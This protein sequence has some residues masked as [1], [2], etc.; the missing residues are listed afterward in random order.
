LVGVGL[1][2][3]FGLAAARHGPSIDEGKP[4]TV[5]QPSLAAK[6]AE[7]AAKAE[8]IRAAYV[9]AMLQAATAPAR[10]VEHAPSDDPQVNEPTPDD[11]VRQARS[12]PIDATWAAEQTAK[13]EAELSLAS[14]HLD[15]RYD[16]LACRTKQCTVDLEWRTLKAARTAF[17][18]GFA[19]EL[20]QTKCVQ[21]L[22]LPES[23]REDE[24]ARGTLILTC[25]RTDAV[26]AQ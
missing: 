14:D 6:P 22:L 8:E 23:A 1:A 18:T 7:P 16:N 26:A 11:Y 19:N 17:K 12:E 25:A 24:P 13:L 4:N 10:E 3:G 5:A 2:L 9:N 21:R 15:F 20:K